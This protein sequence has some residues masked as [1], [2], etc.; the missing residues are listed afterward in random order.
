VSLYEAAYALGGLSALFGSFVGDYF[1]DLPAR[2][3]GPVGW[4]CFAVAALA[5]LLFAL[6][7][8]V[9][10]TR[11]RHGRNGRRYGPIAVGLALAFVWVQLTFTAGWIGWSALAGMG[12]TS[13]PIDAL[14]DKLLPPEWQ[15]IL[16]QVKGL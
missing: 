16:A 11:A 12:L 10:A 15:A 6:V 9:A 14:V 4:L 13:A 8:V 5:E 7:C 1:L 2:H 3:N